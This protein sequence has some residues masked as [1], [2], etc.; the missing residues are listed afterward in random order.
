[1][2]RAPQA[3]ARVECFSS[4]CLRRWHRG[5]ISQAA[6]LPDALKSTSCGSLS[7]LKYNVYLRFAVDFLCRIK[8]LK[9]NG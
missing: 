1:L 9:M 8:W 2:T 7:D 5:A 6:M 3:G 4:Q